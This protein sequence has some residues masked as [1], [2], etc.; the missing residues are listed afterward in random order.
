MPL[1]P[2]EILLLL[3]RATLAGADD[4]TE[5]ELWGGELH[6]SALSAWRPEPSIARRRLFRSARDALRR[7][8]PA[9]E[10][11]LLVRRST[12]RVEWL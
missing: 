2:P 10:P 1:S 9:L 8:P 5:R 3:P 6:Q 4:L 7:V 12:C 11:D